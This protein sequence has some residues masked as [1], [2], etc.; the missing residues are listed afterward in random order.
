MYWEYV[1]EPTHENEDKY[2]K[3]KKF[4]SIHIKKAKRKYY[5][6]YFKKYS[7]NSKKQWQMINSILN[8]KTKTKIKISK[9]RY[10]GSDVTDSQQIAESFNDYFCN[11]GVHR[12]FFRRRRFDGQNWSAAAV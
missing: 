3:M 7:S 6:S 9:I 2:K 1:K 11:R 10:N 5:N 12:V 4:V 8:R